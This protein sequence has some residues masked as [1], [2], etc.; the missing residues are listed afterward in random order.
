M[1]KADVGKYIDKKLNE[2]SDWYLENEFNM[3]RKDIG[4][5]DY[6]EMN[7]ENYMLQVFRKELTKLNNMVNDI[8]EN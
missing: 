1:A 5:T 4:S 3:K 8:E 7:T 6:A 2:Y